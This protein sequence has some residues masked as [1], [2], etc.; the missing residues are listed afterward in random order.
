MLLWMH[1]EHALHSGGGGAAAAAGSQQGLNSW[2]ACLSVGG[3]RWNTKGT[4]RY[5]RP[6][7]V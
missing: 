6:V 2:C 5:V 1:I 7:E 4:T 3:I